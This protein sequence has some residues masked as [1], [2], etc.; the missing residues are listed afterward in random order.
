M[1]AAECKTGGEEGD[2]DKNNRKEKN[3][4]WVGEN[5]VFDKR[6]DAR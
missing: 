6:R 4:L 1:S 2:V 5:F 3:S